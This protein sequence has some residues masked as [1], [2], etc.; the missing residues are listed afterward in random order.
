MSI[1]W[2]LISPLKKPRTQQPPV[3][4][5][6]GNAQ[7]DLMRTVLHTAQL[8]HDVVVRIAHT[9]RIRQ[10]DLRNRRKRVTATQAVAAHPAILPLEDRHT[11][12][13]PR[14]QPET[15]PEDEHRVHVNARR[16][17]EVRLDQ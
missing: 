3:A 12:A 16:A 2:C 14:T 11:R 10:V 7:C 4:A 6:E 15:L 8:A 1:V 17:P 13:P 5:A 9:Q